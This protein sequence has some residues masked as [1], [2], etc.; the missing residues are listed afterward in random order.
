M[1][2]ASST[3]STSYN[4]KLFQCSL[5]I[6]K[7]W[8]HIT[9]MSRSCNQTV[10]TILLY[11]MLF[12]WNNNNH[13][14][15]PLCSPIVVLPRYPRVIV[16]LPLACGSGW[17]IARFR[18]SKCLNFLDWLNLLLSWFWGVLRVEKHSLLSLSWNQSW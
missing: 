14:L 12:Y 9:T 4:K 10:F 11:W 1:P 5:V 6:C 3:F 18:N 7:S 17:P 8:K 16:T 15:L 2:H 13:F